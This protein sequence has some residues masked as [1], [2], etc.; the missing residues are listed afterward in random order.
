MQYMV[1]SYFSVKTI[2]HLINYFIK[3][4]LRNYTRIV[5]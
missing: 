3:Q 5:F 4:N 1:L 2:K